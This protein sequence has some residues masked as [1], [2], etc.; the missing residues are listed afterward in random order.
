MAAHSFLSEFPPVSTEQWES[1]IRENLKGADYSSKLIWHPEEGLA[2]RPYYRADDFA[3]LSFPDAAPGEFPFV[4]GT[5]L[6][7]GWR[8]REKIDASDPEEANRAACAA[9]MAGA[10]EIAFSGSTVENSSRLALVL[11]NL[12][13]IPICFDG[14]GKDAAHILVERLQKRPHGADVSGGH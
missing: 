2:V 10:E 9:V 6:A 5:R 13:E 4:R 7:G 11:A 1:L 12:N 3:G 14:L 8:I